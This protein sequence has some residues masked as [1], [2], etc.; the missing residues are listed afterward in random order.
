MHEREKAEYLKM[1]LIE[2]LCLEKVVQYYRPLI[3]TSFAE[4]HWIC[5]FFLNKFSQIANYMGLSWLHIGTKGV[6]NLEMSSVSKISHEERLLPQCFSIND[7]IIKR[8][9]NITI[10]LKYGKQNTTH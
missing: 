2:N 10:M 7:V 4:K 5:E 6:N 1:F 3:M 8:V 9:Y